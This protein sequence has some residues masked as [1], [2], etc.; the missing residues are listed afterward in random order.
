MELAQSCHA[1]TGSRL[2]DHAV[3][4]VQ[5]QSVE[6]TGCNGSGQEVGGD[7]L[8]PVVDPAVI[9]GNTLNPELVGNCG[10]ESTLDL[11]GLIQ[12]GQGAAAQAVAGC[13]SST[14]G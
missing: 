1:C 3:R 5:V 11:E 2:I 13:C 8:V 12:W 6:R 14:I 7:G 10:Q 9:P 4:N